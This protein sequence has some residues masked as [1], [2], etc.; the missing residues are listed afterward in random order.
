MYSA[1]SYGPS[2]STTNYA[3]WR[4]IGH[5]SPDHWI[6]QQSPVGPVEDDLRPLAAVVE[7][8]AATARNGDHHLPQIAMCVL[9]ADN[10]RLGSIHVVYTTNVE[11]NVGRSSTATSVPRSSPRSAKLM[12]CAM[13]T[14]AARRL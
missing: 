8:E 3:I 9:A 4:E 10:A 2:A 1:G 14:V 5:F 12:I 11:G 6:D 7:Q 13:V